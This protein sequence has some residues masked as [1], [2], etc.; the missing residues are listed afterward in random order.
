MSFRLPWGALAGLWLASAMSVSAQV[1]TQESAS[2][3]VFPKV[4]ADGTW[5]TTI[6]IANGAN[7][8]SRAICYYVNAQL[9]FPD[10]PESPQSNPRLWI[11]TDFTLSL[12]QQQPTHWVVSR[13]RVISERDPC[14]GSST[15]CDLAGPLAVPIPPVVEDFIGEIVCI[16]TD[17]SGAPWTG[18]A[19]RG[20]ATLTHLATGEV[21]K[22]PAVGLAGLPSNDADG[23]LCLGGEPNEVCPLGAEY[24]ACPSHW[25]VSHPSDFDDRDTDQ[26]ASRTRLTIVPCTQDFDAQVPGSVVV[27]IIITNELEQTFS[28]SQ[29]V[30]CWADFALGEYNE[31]FTRDVVGSDWLQTEIRVA[32]PNSGGVMLMQQTEHVIPRPPVFTATAEIPQYVRSVGDG[33]LITLPQE[34]IP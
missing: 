8:P 18:N 15:D 3:L 20:Y 26:N 9:T 10:L 34:V 32:G 16:E 27:Q 23:R 1:S 2:I 28:A 31:L 6:Q 19:L 4:V 5:D 13:G 24:A 11:E 25:T 33:D 7:R 22:Y 14:N 29:S 30:Q 21:V 17:R 12:L